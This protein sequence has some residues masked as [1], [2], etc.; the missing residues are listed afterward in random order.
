MPT[1]CGSL[2]AYGAH[3]HSNKQQYTIT[4]VF[5]A[6]VVVVSGFASDMVEPASTEN[7]DGGAGLS[8]SMAM[9][10]LDFTI[11]VLKLYLH[12]FRMHSWA[13]P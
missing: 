2:E 11:H 10:K 12:T 13:S 4:V 9:G 7:G 6:S 5:V 8:N 1:A 3:P